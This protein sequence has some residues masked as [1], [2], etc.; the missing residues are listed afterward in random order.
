MSRYFVLLSKEL[1]AITR[2]KTIMFAVLVQFFIASFSSVIMVGLM[3]FYDPVSLG[4]S[5]RLSVTVG[6]VGDMQ[7]PMLDYLRERNLP[8]RPYND[9]AAAEAAFHSGSIDT[10]MVVPRSESGTVDMKLVLPTADTRKTIILLVLNEP[11]KKFENY[12][13][14]A[15]GIELKYKDMGGRPNTTYEFLYSLIIP[16]LMFFPAIIAGSIVIDTI[17][18]EFE[19]K[20]FDT[21]LAAPVTPGQVFAAKISAAT[22]SAAIQVAL[23]AGLLRL[24][25]HIIQ[26]LVVVLA[27]AVLIAALIA[28]GAAGIALYFKDRERAQFVYS[29]ALIIAAGLGYFLD[30]SPFSAA[31]NLA[32]GVPGTEPLKV[33]FYLIPLLVIWFAL[34]KAL[35]PMLVR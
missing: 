9:L 6:F 35:K 25:G 24:N 11:L 15:N 21:L 13:R 34:R 3:T 10:I 31:T 14:Q 20:T 17:S 2:E 27:L 1:R 32:A 4:E 18:E 12:L 29:I 30:P 28:T 5:A 22:S 23:W 16:I 33:L 19:N 7:S 26:S 8:V